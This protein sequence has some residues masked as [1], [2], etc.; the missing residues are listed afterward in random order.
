MKSISRSLPA[1][2]RCRSSR[3]P[4]C[5]AQR[6]PAKARGISSDVWQ[7]GQTLTQYAVASATETAT[8]A[9][10]RAMGSTTEDSQHSYHEASSETLSGT[11]L[12]ASLATAS[13]WSYSTLH[14]EGSYAGGSYALSSL[15]Y[16]ESATQ[17]STAQETATVSLT[18]LS[19][20]SFTYSGLSTQTSTFA[21]LGS[22]SHPVTLTSGRTA[23]GMFVLPV[24]LGLATFFPL[25]PEGLVPPFWRA[26]Q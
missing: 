22:S 20:G 16:D 21:S 1:D 12:V 18:L 9:P 25:G 7:S 26:D 14:D 15:V 5:G 13:G 4:F 2:W 11:R 8:V 24:V 3:S 17:S 10:G 23:W 6:G 19:S